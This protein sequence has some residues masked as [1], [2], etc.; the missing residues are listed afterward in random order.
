MGPCRLITPHPVGV[1]HWNQ[2]IPTQAS[3]KQRLQA[4]SFGIAR[5]TNPSL[6]DFQMC[7]QDNPLKCPAKQWVANNGLPSCPCGKLLT[8]KQQDTNAGWE[9]SSHKV[10]C[11]KVSVGTP[12]KEQLTKPTSDWMR[13]EKGSPGLLSWGNNWT[14]MWNGSA[15][16]RQ[17][18]FPLNWMRLCCL[19]WQ[20]NPWKR[21]NVKRWQLG[22]MPW[23][24]T[25]VQTDC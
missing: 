3:L 2:S 4:L 16:L 6:Q 5:L 8:H 7:N 11:S 24:S 19:R 22:P 12:G 18:L 15:A 25:C 20:L 21:D 1:R 10:Q 14:W 13:D 17:Q 23:S 9:Q